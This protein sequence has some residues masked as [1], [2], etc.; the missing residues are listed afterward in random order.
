MDDMDNDSISQHQI[1]NSFASYLSS[2]SSSSSQST[3]LFYL[4]S[5]SKDR[6]LAIS[7]IKLLMGQVK[8]QPIEQQRQHSELLDIE[9]IDF[10]L[11]R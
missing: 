7:R 2:S 1:Q 4:L 3:S 11:N 6:Q 9:K 8:L 5:S 10:D